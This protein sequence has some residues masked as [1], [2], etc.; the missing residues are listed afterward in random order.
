[1]SKMNIEEIKKKAITIKNIDSSSIDGK[2]LREI[3]MNLKMSQALFADYL[4]VTKKT[5]EKWEQGKNKIKGAAAK[6]VALI[7]KNHEV[8][9]M[10]KEVKVNGE[11]ISFNS[12]KAFS[13]DSIECNDLEPKL[14]IEN[15]MIWKKDNRWETSE[16]NNIGGIKKWE[17]QCMTS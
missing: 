8:L 15:S 11:A 2:R 7:E 16:K 17:K 14:C 5:I 3:R 12:I 6:L 4:G 1:M 9:S 13:F 10:L